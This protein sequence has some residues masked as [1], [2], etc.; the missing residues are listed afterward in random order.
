MPGTSARKSCGTWRR[1]ST[2]WPATSATS[3]TGTEIDTDTLR[4]RLGVPA[5]LAAA[6]AAQLT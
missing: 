3:A 6:I 4:T 2:A 1:G 5:P